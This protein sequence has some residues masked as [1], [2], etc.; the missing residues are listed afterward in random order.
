M[1][2][3][4]PDLNGFCPLSDRKSDLCLKKAGGQ[5]RRNISSCDAVDC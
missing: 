1:H 3:A 2:F 5:W 4:I